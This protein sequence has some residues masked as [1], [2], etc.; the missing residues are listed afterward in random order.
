MSGVRDAYTK[1]GACYDLLVCNQ[2]GSTRMAHIPTDEDFARLYP[3]SYYSYV[4]QPDRLAFFKRL[5]SLTYRRH[6]YIPRFRRLLEVG[7]GRGEFLST[8]QSRG[9]VIGLERSGAARAAAT[10][11]GL[12][13]IVGNVED[14][15]TFADESFDCIYSNHAF[16]HLPHPARSLAS[17][18]RWLR[19]DGEL[20]IGVPNISGAVAR[21]FGKNWYYL[22]PPLHITNSSPAGMRALLDRY[23]FKVER[24]EYNSDPISIPMSIYIACGGSIDR[25]PLPLKLLIGF[26]TIAA[27]PIAKMLDALGAGDC[28]EV[29]ATRA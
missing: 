18:H 3:D 17:M 1:S 5:L 25:V 28:I 15:N 4:D 16:E 13:V 6:R 12:K 10:R 2:C 8:I 20:F 26:L 27:Y 14:P 11:L 23:G 9:E 19:P 29:H 7:C 22:G 24:I 21:I